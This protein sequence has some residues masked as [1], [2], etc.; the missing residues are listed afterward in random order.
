MSPGK[1][2]AG[3]D[4]APSRTLEQIEAML[5]KY[6]C[7]EFSYARLDSG[8]TFEISFRIQNTFVRSTMVMPNREQFFHTS[9]NPWTK[10]P[11][12]AIER[13]WLQ[14]CRSRWRVLHLAIKAKLALIDE[15]IST[16]EREFL[17]DV[18]TGT[19][20]TIGDILIPKIVALTSGHMIE[21]PSTTT[22]EIDPDVID[23][24]WSEE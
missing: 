17:S 8:K 21:I 13:D 20:E 11:E 2:A 5:V 23:G 3:T 1:Y 22:T 7:S 4:V 10:R 18:V 9:R 19:G 16:V 14:A 6:G 12:S 24:E 15:G